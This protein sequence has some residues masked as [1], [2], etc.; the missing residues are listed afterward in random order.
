MPL[1]SLGPE[2]IQGQEPP[3]S[4]MLVSETDFFLHLLDRRRLV[5][6]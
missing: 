2:F 5:V 3:A 1:G 4:A 6:V